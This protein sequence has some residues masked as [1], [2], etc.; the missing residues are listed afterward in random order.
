M[1]PETSVTVDPDTVHTDVVREL[2]LTARVELADA[3]TVNGDVPNVWFESPANVMVWLS[4]V[5]VKL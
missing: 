4:G 1:P 5:T 2:K 3:L